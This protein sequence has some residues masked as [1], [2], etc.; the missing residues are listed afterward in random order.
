MVKNNPSLDSLVVVGDVMQAIYSFRNTSPENLIEFSDKFEN[1]QDVDLKQN[2]RSKKEIIDWA[3]RIIKKESAT[4][5][6]I[7][8][9]FKGSRKPTLRVYKKRNDRID[10]VVDQVADC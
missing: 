10:F 4:P 7:K 8:P 1:V 9:T 5:N 3:N 2:F 6:L